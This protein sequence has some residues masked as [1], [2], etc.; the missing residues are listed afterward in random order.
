VHI[1]QR[2]AALSGQ[3]AELGVTR[4]DVVAVMLPNRVA[5]VLAVFAAWRLGAAATPINPAFTAP[6]HRARG[7]RALDSDPVRRFAAR[8]PDVRI[9]LG[10]PAQGIRGF[11]RS[12]QQ[13]VAARRVALASA[14]EVVGYGDEGVAIVSVLARDIDTTRDWVLEVLGPLARDEDDAARQRHT[15]RTFLATGGSYTD[16]A[17]R[18]NL[19][20]NSVR[21]RVKKAETE[22]GRPITDDRLDVEL[23]LQVCHFLGEA[24]LSE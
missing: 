9:A 17:A 3:L 16:S 6:C 20:H 4:G 18:L 2:V 23:A 10:L 24:V 13:A 22:R 14:S 5:L 12:H 11:H 15:L 19:H 8:S 1:A 21:Y 7:T